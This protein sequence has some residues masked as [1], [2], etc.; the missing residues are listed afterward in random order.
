M[1][2]GHGEPEVPSTKQ[3]FFSWPLGTVY[4]SASLAE[5][6]F[7]MPVFGFIYCK[8]IPMQNHPCC[9][10]TQRQVTPCLFGGD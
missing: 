9:K 6:L 5:E 3:L 2:T 8:I 7:G 4:P 10:I 1:A